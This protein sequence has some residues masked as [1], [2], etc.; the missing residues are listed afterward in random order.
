MRRFLIRSIHILLPLTLLFAAVTTRVIEP[1]FLEQFKVLWFDQ[2][3]VRFPRQYDPN[4]GVRIVDID[5]ESLRRLGQ[6]PWPRTKLAALVYQLRQAGAAVV[7]FDIVFAEA[8]RTSPQTVVKDWPDIPEFAALREQI[9]KMPDH[10]QA[11]AEYIK[12][13]GGIVTGFVLTGS[14][15]ATPPVQ[16]GNFA[17]SSADATDNPRNYVFK[18]PRAI[19]N[20]RIFEEAADGN[21]NFNV[22]PDLD[23]LIR[24]VPLVAGLQAGVSG[25]DEDPLYPLISIEALRV[26][27]GAKTMKI[28]LS[29]GSGEESFGERTGIDS[30]KVGHFEIP[31]DRRGRMWVYYSGRQQERYLPVWKVLEGSAD[32][33]L[34]DGHIILVGASAAGLLDLRSTP[35]DSALPGVEVHAEIIEQILTGQYLIEPDWFL[36][37]EL[38]FIVGLGLVLI[39]LLPRLGAVICAVIGSVAVAT[40]VGLSV[41]AYLDLNWLIE[42]WSSSGAVLA[43]YLSASLISYIRTES[44]RKQ[45]RGAFAQYLSPALVE[46]LAEEPDRLKL[47]GE[48][49]EMSF[50][51]CDV[52]GFTAIS[53][54]FKSNPQG[55]T[56][57]INRLLTPLTNE[58]LSRQGTIDKYMGDCIMAFWNAPLD[59]AEHAV[60]SCHAVL[61]MFEAL[62]VLN[63]ERRLEDE[64]AGRKHLPLNVGAGINTGECVVGNMGSAQ[65]F[66]YSVLGDP[67]N[68]AARLESQSKNYGVKIVLGPKTEAEAA[69]A[70]FAT[71]ELDLIQVKGQSVGVSIHCLLGD[72][73]FATTPEFIAVKEKHREFIEHY[74]SQRWDAADASMVT[75]RGLSGGLALALDELYDLYRERIDEYRENPPPIDWD[76]VFV[77]TTK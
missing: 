61:A 6:W 1:R 29:G 76:G 10:D 12:A 45:V 23:G 69:K 64:A 48:T 16:R 18:Y 40:V 57:L 72:A 58:I 35:I 74:R 28:K 17:F 21:G 65:R 31:T 70:G 50:L 47:G 75:C 60:H 24:R 38:A 77:A 22:L 41:Y 13:V 53:E 34:L 37:A 73:E 59:D 36:G 8:D 42:P 56:I 5:D 67:V 26:V 63:E 4:S 30:I 39:V 32:K 62:D 52:R 27:Q 43:I 71:L 55:L 49:K 25:N 46:Q 9:S 11:F 20:L 7:T 51:F 14:G 3:N 33:T 19:P 66:D 68:L 54:T 15:T 44:E 2:L